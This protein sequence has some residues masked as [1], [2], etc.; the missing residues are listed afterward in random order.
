[1]IAA[2]YSKLSEYRRLDLCS[3]SLVAQGISTST[4]NDEFTISMNW[5]IGS[6]CMDSVAHPETGGFNYRT[7]VPT[8]LVHALLGSELL[9]PKLVVIPKCRKP[10]R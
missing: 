3:M 8:P 4:W 1:M 5:H 7:A 10:G 6:K 9:I 2:F